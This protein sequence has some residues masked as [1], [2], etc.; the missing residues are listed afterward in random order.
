MKVVTQPMVKV[1]KILKL[2]IILVSRGIHNTRSRILVHDLWSILMNLATDNMTISSCP[3][4]SLLKEVIR[5]VILTLVL[6]WALIYNDMRFGLLLLAYPLSGGWN[7]S[8]LIWY[9][10]YIILIVMDKILNLLQ[11][12]VIESTIII[13][14]CIS[15]VKIICV[16][17]SL[18]FQSFFRTFLGCPPYLLFIF[19][20]HIIDIFELFSKFWGNSIGIF[21]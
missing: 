13:C 15:G 21:D 11:I 7:C 1:V 3:C 17:N 2:Q 8:L 20:K 19:I 5:I 14:L 12:I 6:V 10:V 9:L 18:F 4:T 16:I